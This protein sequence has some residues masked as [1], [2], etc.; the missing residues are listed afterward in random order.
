MNAWD[1]FF[2][3]LR[4]IYIWIVYIFLVCLVAG[5]VLRLIAWVRHHL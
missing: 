5:L 3:R 4:K 2:G 1:D